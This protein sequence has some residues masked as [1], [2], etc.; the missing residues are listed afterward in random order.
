MKLQINAIPAYNDN[1]IWIVHDDK[2]ALVVD[3][4]LAQPVEDYLNKHQ[5][6]LNTIIITHHH[7]DHING[8]DELEKKWSCQVYGPKDDR[9]PFTVKVVQEGDTVDD[10]DLGFHLNVIET[11]GHTLSHV[12]YYNE[13]LLFCG[14]TLFSMGCGKM[15]EGSADQFMS[16]LTK[17]KQLKPD[18]TIYCTHEYTLSN[19]DFAIFLE[20]ENAEIKLKKAASLKLR[21]KNKPTIPVTLSDELKINPFLRTHDALFVAYLNQ[22]FNINIDNEV[23]CFA[24]LRSEKDNY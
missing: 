20:P 18:T 21:S 1:Y 22:R 8:V 19:I 9:I 6:R 15:F 3:P 5:L 12:C 17:L 7:W 4:G 24:Y 14:D 10:F 13:E 16:S 11:P 2:N 23:N